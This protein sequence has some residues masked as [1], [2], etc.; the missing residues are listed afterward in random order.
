[1]HPENCIV[2]KASN[3]AISAL[4]VGT[5]RI[6]MLLLK[7]NILQSALKTFDFCRNLPDYK[8]HMTGDISLDGA[9]LT[10]HSFD[11]SLTRHKRQS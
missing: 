2:W 10:A 11:Q 9:S 1:M 7:T 4:R 3:I 5:Y 6:S 8:D